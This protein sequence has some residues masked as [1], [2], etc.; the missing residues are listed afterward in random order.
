MNL[1][2]KNKTDKIAC[3][4]STGK[5]FSKILIAAI[6]CLILPL[7]CFAYTRTPDV[8][9]AVSYELN[10]NI[11]EGETTLYDYCTTGSGLNNFYFFTYKNEEN[12]IQFPIQSATNTIINLSAGTAYKN[13]GGAESILE[14]GDSLNQVKIYCTN[15]DIG[16]YGTF[17]EFVGIIFAIDYDDYFVFIEEDEEISFGDYLNNI[18]IITA[19]SSTGTVYYYIPFFL[20]LAALSI[21]ILGA[22]T[23]IIFYKYGT[24]DN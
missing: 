14:I 13:I 10:L 19:S 16:I 12:Y 8:N 23:F 15:E 24:R 2:K 22:T 21:I 3:S 18:A 5:R 1:T 4:G 17:D 20:F 6:T 7:N 9:E 11:I